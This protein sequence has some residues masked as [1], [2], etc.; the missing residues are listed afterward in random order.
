MYVNQIGCLEGINC[1][2][3]AN[4]KKNSWLQNLWTFPTLISKE[5]D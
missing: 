4:L 2:S 3:V 1:E 5:N